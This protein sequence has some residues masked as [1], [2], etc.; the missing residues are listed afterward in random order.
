MLGPPC[1][2]TV[3][4]RYLGRMPRLVLILIDLVCVV[5]F[6][7]IGRS[8][9]AEVLTVEDVA[10]TAAPFV[11][12]TLLAWVALILRPLADTLLKQGVI[13]WLSTLVLGMVFRILVGQVVEVSFVLVA[14]LTLAAFL[15]GWRGIVV[16]VGRRKAAQG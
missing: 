9:H 8:S 16:L 11:A 14:G 15:L 4:G 1:R 13:V 5:V 10:R 7:A 12:G 2:R 6:A 3:L